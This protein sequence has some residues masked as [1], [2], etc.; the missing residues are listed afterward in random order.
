MTDTNDRFFD[1]D[2]T[3]IRFVDEGTGAAV[4]FIHGFTLDLEMGWIEPGILSAVT[5]AGYRA[6]AYDS[7]GHG[8]SD[9]PHDVS[10]YGPVEVA[11][12]IRLMDHLAID[13]THVV[14]WSRG[15]FVAGRLRASH[16]AR[17]ATLTV[18]GFGE[19]GTSD[20]AIS[21]PARGQTAA[22]LEAGDYAALVRMVIPDGTAEEVK[23]WSTVL[24]E[25]NDHIALA[26]AIR[27]VWPILTAEELRANRTPALCIIGDEDL[28]Y[29][30]VQRMR[31]V[32]SGLEMIVVP[33]ADHGTTLARAEFTTALLG[34]LHKHS[35]SVRN[36]AR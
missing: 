30:E 18:A 14:G 31:A 35:E 3:R 19:S 27:S 1:S 23:M 13:R 33:E 2:Q 26:A 20:G 22:I 17:V 28:L 32:M 21:E 36:S 25:R 34:F 11:D 10:A 5:D 8:L 15:G 7:R 24:A 12:A 16:P 9:K 6:V 29:A 4:L